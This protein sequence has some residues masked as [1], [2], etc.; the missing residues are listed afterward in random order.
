MLEGS[1]EG[2]IVFGLLCLPRHMRRLP[3]LVLT[4]LIPS[5]TFVV[6]EMVAGQL[7]LIWM[8]MDLGHTGWPNRY[9]KFSANYLLLAGKSESL[10]ITTGSLS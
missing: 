10:Y 1:S 2:V 6:I 8:S 4:L 9:T 3:L 7:T 5:Y